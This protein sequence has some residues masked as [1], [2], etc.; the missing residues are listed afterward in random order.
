MWGE[1]LGQLIY[2]HHTYAKEWN[3]SNAI[4]GKTSNNEIKL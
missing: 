3:D 4:D 2:S 1:S